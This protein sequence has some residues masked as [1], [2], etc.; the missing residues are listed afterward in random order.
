[1]NKKK[2]KLKHLSPFSLKGVV[3]RE[4]SAPSFQACTLSFEFWTLMIGM[5]VVIVALT[6]TTVSCALK[7]KKLKARRKRKDKKAIKV[8]LNSIKKMHMSSL[9]WSYY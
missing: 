8:A 2:K 9:P 4:V 1:M 3:I 5:A 6:A 7:Q